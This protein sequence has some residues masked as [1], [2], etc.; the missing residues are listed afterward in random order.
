MTPRTQLTETNGADGR[1]YGVQASTIAYLVNR[2]GLPSLIVAGVFATA[3]WYLPKYLERQSVAVEKM[4][5]AFTDIAKTEVEIKSVV[6]E[7]KECAKET[8]AF[9]R[10]VIEEHTT[11]AQERKQMLDDHKQIIQQLLGKQ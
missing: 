7:I 3:L 1:I 5:G 10:T 6:S 8:Q 9:Q 2:V 4:A 11:A